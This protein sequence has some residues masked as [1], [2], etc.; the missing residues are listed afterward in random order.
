MDLFYELL[1]DLQ[2]GH[3]LL[4]LVAR[5]SVLVVDQVE[6]G[7]AFDLARRKQNAGK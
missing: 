5:Q 2:F 3:R 4:G 1:S 7:Q 6:D